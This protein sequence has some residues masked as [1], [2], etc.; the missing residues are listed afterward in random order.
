MPKSEVKS[1]LYLFEKLKDM[2]TLLIDDD[3]W[4]RDAMTLFF[5]GEG[6]H[7]LA[8]ETAEKGMKMLDTQ[9]YD[10]IIADYRLPGMDGLD[11]FGR[12]KESQSE[13]LTVL[14][15]AYGSKTVLS[16]AAELGIMGF[17]D[18]PFTIEMLEDT[19]SGLLERK[20]N[21]LAQKV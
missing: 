18:K 19:L 14:I 5:E 9:H 17:I 20:H 4:I 12:I 7:L 6:C 10:V 11:F 16:K 8:V 15:T 13:A 3:E 1:G 21:P 2:K